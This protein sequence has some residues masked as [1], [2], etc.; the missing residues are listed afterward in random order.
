MEDNKSPSCCSTTSK[1]IFDSTGSMPSHHASAIMVEV[2]KLA[3]AGDS[4][5]DVL[6]GYLALL[7][8]GGSSENAKGTFGFMLNNNR[9]E[10]ESLRKLVRSDPYHAT[11]RQFARA[12]P[13]DVHTSLSSNKLTPPVANKIGLKDAQVYWGFDFADRSNNCP[14]E[15][16]QK[17]QT[18]LEKALD[19]RSIRR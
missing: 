4:G 12:I 14:D 1:F 19:R 2:K 7:G 11:L 3:K 10:L 16:K 15:V 5:D 18:H 17:L 6:E 9:Y 8:M 13:D